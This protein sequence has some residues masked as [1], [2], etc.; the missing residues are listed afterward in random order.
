[1]Q[2]IVGGAYFNDERIGFFDKPTPPLSWRD[3]VEGKRV[4]DCDSPVFIFGLKKWVRRM[5]KAHC[6]YQ[7]TVEAIVR[8]L[9]INIGQSTPMGV[10]DDCNLAEAR[11][12]GKQL[13]KSLFNDFNCK[14]Y[15]LRE[16]VGK[17]DPR[18]IPFSIPSKSNL[19]LGRSNK[20]KARDVYFCGDDW[21]RAE[22]L[23]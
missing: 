3:V 21:I 1:M 15:L 9:K 23:T 20:E 11:G 8:F 6:T 4:T 16:Y 18:V 2:I 19:H 7:Q 10:L 22:S 17:Y 13:R 12:I 5:R 14:V